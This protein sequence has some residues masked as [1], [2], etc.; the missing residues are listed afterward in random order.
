MTSTAKI[1]AEAERLDQELRATEDEV[2]NYIGGCNDYI[3]ARML[4]SYLGVATNYETEQ[5][6]HTDDLDRKTELRIEVERFVKDNPKLARSLYSKHTDLL[7]QRADPLGNQERINNSVTYALLKIA[8]VGLLLVILFKILSP[9]GSGNY[10][11]S[12][13]VER[14]LGGWC[15]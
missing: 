7:Y 1:K 3:D 14:C 6:H 5:R 11:G 9:V 8:V 10:M 2:W 15:R 13:E 4:M 12:P